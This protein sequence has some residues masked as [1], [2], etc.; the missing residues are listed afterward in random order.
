[1][2]VV[3]NKKMNIEVALATVPLSRDSGTVANATSI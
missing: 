3:W 2:C 1:M